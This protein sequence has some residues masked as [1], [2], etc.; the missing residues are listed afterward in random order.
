MELKSEGV[1]VFGPAADGNIP[2]IDV[3]LADNDTFSFGRANAVV[4]G[5]FLAYCS[6]CCE[7]TCLRCED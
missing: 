1:Q 6:T 2:G 5:E 3:R 4:M 7:T